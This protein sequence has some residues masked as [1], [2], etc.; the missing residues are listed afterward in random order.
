MHELEQK[1][2]EFGA[3]DTA[4]DSIHIDEWFENATIAFTGKE[5]MGKV[6]CNF[7]NC[8]EISLK[9][10]KTYPK[11]KNKDGSL[12]YKYFIQ[13]IEIVE[14]KGYYMFKISAWPLEGE[15]ICKKTHLN[16]EN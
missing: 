12:D 13:D 2:I 11:G 3:I 7:E 4:I 14:N 10:D 5:N 8:F 15:I 6:I 16:I 9:H 1:I